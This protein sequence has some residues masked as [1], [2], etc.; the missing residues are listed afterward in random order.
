MT[1]ENL[2]MNNENDINHISKGPDLSVVIIT[3]NEE[4][5]ISDCIRS[6][7]ES[8]DNAVN[9]GLISSSEIILADSASTD[10][11]IEIAKE[12]PIKIVQLKKNW[13]LSASAGRYIG[14]L[15]S[16]GKY[17]FFMDGDCIM[18]KNW[19]CVSIP[20][21]EDK[22]VG[23]LDGIEVEYV[24]NQ[25]S[26]KNAFESLQLNIDEV[27]EAETLG[28]AFF[29]REVLEEV[30]PYDP[31]LI[32]AEDRD[33]SYR[34]KAA[35]YLLLRLPQPCVTHFWA[36]KEG[37]LSLKRY[38]QSVYVWSKGE[39]Q[40]FRL[41]RKNRNLAH[42]YLTRY[43]NTFYLRVYGLIFLFISLL[44][45]N[46]LAV[47]LASQMIIAPIVAI[48][49]DLVLAAFA[50][51]YMAI[52]KKGGKWDEFVYSFHIIPY[53]F[54][55]HIGFVIGLLKIPRHPA[56]YPTDAVIIKQ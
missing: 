1:K 40:A 11:T 2:S 14:Y 16:K 52:R 21:I 46:A 5:M 30:G 29:R 43:I 20:Y 51:A 38:L 36:K 23:G 25:S 33:I 50:V 47:I 48:I 42:Q 32:G 27:L 41:S 18:D 13:P 7:I 56:N 44:Y 24:S 4:D 55:R 8:I 35:G 19:F 28:K 53:V 10:R 15:H 26:F 37:N 34:I 39:G 22:K 6:V 45:M 49:V 17:V 12:F 54:V 9:A 31:Y 3:R